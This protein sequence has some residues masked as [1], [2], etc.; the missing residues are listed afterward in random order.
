MATI[1]QL[2]DHLEKNNDIAYAFSEGLKT[3]RT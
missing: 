1:Q 2:K 3:A